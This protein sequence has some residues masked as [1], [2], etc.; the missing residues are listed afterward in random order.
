MKIF[1]KNHHSLLI[2]SFGIRERIYMA[3]TV[4]VYFD[5][6]AP[7]DP[8]SEQDLWKT[9][10]ALLGKSP[11]L[12]QGMPKPRGEFLV[13]GSCFAPRGE[14]RNA[15]RVTVRVGGLTKAL[16]V[17]GDRYWKES[18]GRIRTITP[19]QPFSEMPVVYERAFGGEGFE[20]NPTGRGI[21][22]LEMSPGQ[23]YVPLPNIE[24]PNR[25][26]G[27]L[28][29]RPD[30]AGFG[31]LDLTWSQR[32]SKT[33]TYDDKWLRENWPYF[34][35]DM[36][37]E[38]FN[39]AAED[40]YMKGFFKGDESLLIAGMNPDVPVI[41]SR[42][43]PLRIRSFVT[44]RES[45]EKEEELFQE[46]PTRIDT[47]W[48]F[49][50]ILRGIVMHRGTTE[51]LDEEYADVVRIFLAT[52]RAA[53][54][55][56]TIEYYMEEE[57]KARELKVPVDMAPFEAGA[58]QIGDAM[59]RLKK[60]PA[61]IEQSLKAS[62]GKAPVMPRSPAET[63][64]EGKGVIRDNLA[65]LDRLEANS[66][67]LHAQ[68]G[69]LVRVDLDM[70]DRMRGSLQSISA[71]IDKNLAQLQ[72][73]VAEAQ[74]LM[75]Q[76]KKD[77]IQGMK[78]QIDPVHLANAGIDPDTFLESKK[79]LRPWHDK[80]FPFVVQCR[81]NLEQDEQTLSALKK[82]G[83]DHRS[84]RKSWMGLNKEEIHEERVDWGLKPERK[85]PGDLKPLSIPAGLVLPHFNDA[86][87]DRITILPPGWE[88]G[89][90]PCSCERVEG[91]VETPLFLSV[92]DGAP[93]IRVA[94]ELQAWYVEKEIGDA[95]SVIAITDPGQKPDEEAAARIEKAPAFIVVMPEKAKESDGMAWTKRFPNA[96]PRKLPKGDTVFAAR[97]R[98]VD[99]RDWIMEAMSPEFVLRHRVAPVLPAPGKPP[100]E[101]DL[102]VPIPKVDVK[103]LID[104]LGAQIKAAQDQAFAPH[105]A[106]MEAAKAKAIEK[107]R[108]AALQAG[109][110]PE[111]VLQN[112]EKP[113]KPSYAAPANAMA[114][115]IME[116]VEATRAAGV[117][118]P[119]MENQMIAEA[120]RIRE[121]GQLA[122]QR[123]E[124]GMA[125]IESARTTI[126]EAAARAKAG[127]MPD[128]ARAKF[129]KHRMDPDKMVRRTREEVLAMHREGESLAFANLSGVD[130]SG[131]D[132][133]TIDLHQAQCVKTN[134]AGT[135]LDGADLTQI[136]F[137][138]SDFSKAS[139]RQSKMDRTMFI[140]TKL[141]GAGF[142]DAK[143]SQTTFLDSDLTGAD[144]S[145]A[146]LYLSALERATITRARFPGM[147]AELSAFS[148]GDAAD[149]DFKDARFARCL[150]RR[151]TLDRADFSRSA[152]P[153]SM[154]M[155][156][157]G[158]AVS[159][160]HADMNKARMSGKNSFLG[161]DF[162]NVR[163]KGGSFREA[164]LSG[165]SFR[166]SVLDGTMLESC[167][168]KGCSFYSVSAKRCRFSKCDLEGADMRFV[169]LLMGSLRK[170]RLVNGDLR[171]ANLFAVDLYRV[172]LGETRLDNANLKFTLLDR[173]TDLLPKGAGKS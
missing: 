161:A 24:Y 31:P 36:N 64:A 59:K 91:S 141:P 90:K 156:L 23:A 149:A 75:T 85:D 10:P 77:L 139:L 25:L 84:I 134:F 104:K 115:K 111:A 28:N 110:D 135:T 15:G 162:K 82:L 78:E 34:P 114:G 3:V 17:F 116:Q 29:D 14:T 44:K 151:L 94:D 19:P 45:L 172:V 43:P 27:D 51:I 118:T 121:Q 167:N 168:L 72:K 87:L 56:K 173:R 32:M 102:T 69:H 153:S 148:D 97:Q 86:L 144:F 108:E 1:K 129:R 124:A 81:R 126:A 79:H 98:G 109:V 8:L 170:S 67:N 12:D 52:E 73:S 131:L 65:L 133:R 136:M 160:Q 26:I 54:T 99:I 119:K 164:D 169:N 53:E 30:P 166:G 57:R 35:A 9:V 105:A 76:G 70:F 42:L 112:M 47:V 49:P 165:S 142:Q 95:C 66:R 48:L 159:F 138:E 113:M 143:M 11:I 5:L 152:F 41:E 7:D 100:T 33:G 96:Q 2:K 106:R 61:D 146:T 120:E 158:E 154:L 22:P 88:E 62:L 117:L 38:F 6:T 89:E 68:F 92:E 80:G 40:Q 128:G 171:G 74:S 20:R 127:E 16:D 4:M 55:P 63:A 145:G 130:L 107:I 103:A 18:S 60:I 123:Y 150:M 132:L 71:N 46:I 13:T 37:Y 93:V 140:K 163:L 83:L 155:E 50:A 58:K 101:E 125:R 147:K 137:I 122:Q 157:R 39:C 21:H